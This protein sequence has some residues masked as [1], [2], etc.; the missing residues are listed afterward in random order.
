ML[1]GLKL[2]VYMDR[3]NYLKLTNLVNFPKAFAEFSA[4][5]L[6]SSI[7]FMSLILMG[8]FCNDSK[9]IPYCSSSILFP[10]MSNVKWF[11]NIGICSR[12][13]A[14]IMAL[15]FPPNLRVVVLIEIVSLFKE[16]GKFLRPY[17]IISNPYTPISKSSTLMIK[18]LTH[19]SRNINSPKLK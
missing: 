3:S 17:L 11:K 2:Q 18:S 13:S 16:L 9:I 5:W 14:R 19:L 8:R 10:E 7:I 4:I 6:E 15:S 12:L 1:S